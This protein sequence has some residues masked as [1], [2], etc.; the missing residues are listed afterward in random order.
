M[1]FR[2]SIELINRQSCG[3]YICNMV[4][5]IMG[6]VM[7]V[8]RFV[9]YSNNNNVAQTIG[10]A[11]MLRSTL[12]FIMGGAINHGLARHLSNDHPVSIWCTCCADMR[13]DSLKCAKDVEF[14]LFYA[15]IES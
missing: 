11:Y 12:Q 1:E 7:L 10:I 15:I 14:A 5:I 2:E 4:T 8:G 6:V 9:M 13:L 3:R